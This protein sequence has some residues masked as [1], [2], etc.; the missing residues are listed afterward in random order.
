MTITTVRIFIA[1]TLDGATRA[2]VE[3][4]IDELRNQPA[5]AAVRVRWVPEA[6]LHLTLRFLGE[7]DEHRTAA[8]RETLMSAWSQS[9]FKA[10]LG[11]AGLFPPRGAPR[12]VWLDVRDGADRLHELQQEV[13]RRLARIGFGRERRPF[14]PHLT[15]GRMKRIA[16]RAERALNRTVEALDVPQTEWTVD[17]VVLMESRLSSEGAAYH[18]LAAATLLRSRAMPPD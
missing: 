4:L 12:V 8:V 17:R 13:E 6:N 15:I 10:S 7:L 9:P 16:R 11:A 2:R 1:V 3:A 5:A 14:R 18:E